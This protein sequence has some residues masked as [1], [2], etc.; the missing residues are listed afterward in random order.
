MSKC[1][2]LEELMKIA[3]IGTVPWRTTIHEEIVNMCIKRRAIFNGKEYKWDKNI[4]K[5]QNSAPKDN[6]VVERFLSSFD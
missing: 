6:P 1:N 4:S 3:V 2:D 5:L